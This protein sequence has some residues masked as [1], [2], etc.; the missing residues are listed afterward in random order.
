[1]DKRVLFDP[2]VLTLLVGFFIPIGVAIITKRFADSWWKA[3]ILIVLSALAAVLQQ[4]SQNGGDFDLWSTV[5]IFLQMVATAIVSHF[6]VLQPMH[7]T[8]SGGVIQ[9]AIPGGIGGQHD[10]RNYDEPRAA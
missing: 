7:I 10:T 9:L 4:V 5:V 3:L 6:G 2:Q 8:S 1:M